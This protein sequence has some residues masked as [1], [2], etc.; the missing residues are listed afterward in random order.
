VHKPNTG[1]PIAETMR[2]MNRLKDERL[3][4]NIGVSNFTVE[5]MEQAQQSSKY[6]IVANQV[7][8][9]LAVREIERKQVREYCQNNDM[10]LIAWRPIRDIGEMTLVPLIQKLCEKYQKTTM[11]IAINWLTSQQNIVTLTK[12]SSA[13]HLEE[14][15]GGVG[16][17]MESED[18]EKLRREFP[19]QI[20]VSD[21]VPLV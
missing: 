6:R 20:D 5:R 2:A 12:T 19:N 1:I 10:M 4:R 18:I 7:H 9:N 16:W 11:Q 17:E 13:D 15:M 21:A 8:Y 3:I 14:N